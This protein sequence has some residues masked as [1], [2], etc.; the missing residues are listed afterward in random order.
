MMNVD[1]TE[2]TMQNGR[3]ASQLFGSPV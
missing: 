1:R 2:G 3:V